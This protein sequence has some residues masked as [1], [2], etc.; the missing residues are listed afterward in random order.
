MRDEEGKASVEEGVVIAWSDLTPDPLW[1]IL[2]RIED[3]P[4]HYG[5]EMN[6]VANTE[7]EFTA[8]SVKREYADNGPQRLSSLLWLQHCE[9]E[10]E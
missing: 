7:G 4:K 10:W 8:G 1:D 2:M 6:M 9:G 3:P 5:S